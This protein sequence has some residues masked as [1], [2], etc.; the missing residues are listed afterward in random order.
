MKI[1]ICINFDIF[2]CYFIC[3]SLYN[4]RKHKKDLYVI[5]FQSMN[6]IFFWTKIGNKNEDKSHTRIMQNWIVFLY[7]LAINEGLWVFSMLF[8][9]KK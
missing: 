5:I 7:S 2:F 4:L 3:K 9:W 1:C 6:K 8:D